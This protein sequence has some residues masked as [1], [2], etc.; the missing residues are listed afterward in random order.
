MMHDANDDCFMESEASHYFPINIIPSIQ[1]M[2][3]AR[4]RSQTCKTMHNDALVWLSK[5]RS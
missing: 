1:Y 2:L 4:K 5:Q 3:V